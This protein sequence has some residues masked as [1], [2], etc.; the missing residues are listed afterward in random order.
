MAKY[1]F[2]NTKLLY[3]N[4]PV[5]LIRKFVERKCGGD[6]ISVKRRPSD[7]IRQLISFLTRENINKVEFPD[8]ILDGNA[9][10][11]GL[12]NLAFGTWMRSDLKNIPFQSY[13]SHVDLKGNPPQFLFS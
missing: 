10:E 8:L 5:N 13:S 1:T 9:P 11:R 4:S 7:E 12:G 2:R 3:R 6:I